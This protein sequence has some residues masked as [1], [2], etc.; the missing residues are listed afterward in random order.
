LKTQKRHFNLVSLGCPKNRVDS[1]RILFFMDNAGFI[2]A[3]DPAVSDV[4]II[5]TCAFIEDAVEES[6]QAIL[7]YRAE[8]RESFLVVAGCMPLR[9]RDELRKS[10]PEVD[11]FIT[12]DQ[13]PDLPTILQ[14]STMSRVQH[15]QVLSQGE[16]TPLSHIA[17]FNDQ[18]EDRSISREDGRTTTG[19]ERILSTPGYAYLKIAEGCNRSCRYCTIPAI[20]GPLRSVSTDALVEEVRFLARSG[21][22]EV[23]LTAQDLTSYGVDRNEKR[24]LLRLLERISAINGI[25]W[26]RLMYLHPN[27][28]PRGLARLIGESENIL[29]YLDIP[30]QHISDK[31]LRSMG[32]PWKGD[33]LRKLVDSLREEINGLVLR[34]TLMVGFPTEGDNE[35]K[36]LQEFVESYRIEH[37][38]VFE[39]SPEEGT[40]AFDLGDPVPRKVKRSRAAAIRRINSRY[41]TRRNQRRIGSVEHGMVESVS[42]ESEFLLQGRAWDQAPEVDGILYIVEGEAQAGEIHRVTITGAH[43]P[44]LFGAIENEQCQA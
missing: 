37:V 29:P 20:R 34:T 35:F 24:G 40:P 16:H 19:A 44:D 15:H 7:N 21:A 9:Y 42:Q 33:R 4:I 23:V 26:I 11:L 41:V 43:G 39:Y 6:I 22:R 17:S 36:E 27:G 14:G 38:G 2:F 13:I 8:H 28:I 25:Q 1:E 10:L 30:F 3:H 32:R 5:N 31:V 18:V 12:P